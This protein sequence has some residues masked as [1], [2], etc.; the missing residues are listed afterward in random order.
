[1]GW[2]G[3]PESHVLHLLLTS[4]VLP[5]W[6]WL[7]SCGS[8]WGWALIGPVAVGSIALSLLGSHPWLP[9]FSPFST[10]RGSSLTICAETTPDPPHQLPVSP[11][12]LQAVSGF[13]VH[14]APSASSALPLE[15]PCLALTTA[16]WASPS[17][18][19]W[20]PSVWTLGWP[21]VLQGCGHVGTRPLQ[22]FRWGGV[23]GSCGPRGMARPSP[24][25]LLCRGSHPRGLQDQDRH[26][27]DTSEPGRP[28]VRQ[29]PDLA[30]VCGGEALCRL[31][32]HQQR[33]VSALPRPS[34]QRQGE[35][36]RP[37]VPAR[38]G[39]TAGCWKS[40]DPGLGRLRGRG[41]RRVV[42]FPLSP[43]EA[44]S[45]TSLRTWAMARGKTGAGSSQP[46]PRSTREA[47][48]TTLSLRPLSVG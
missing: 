47:G 27:R 26:L 8:C 32:Q 13:L 2:G 14:V 1:M 42:P 30:A 44:T 24:W 31:L 23:L 12:P 18:P 16:P 22:A 15:P 45:R 3:G 48:P 19:R 7:G 39:H 20:G 4:G 9:C 28:H 11:Y 33:Q 40:R 46:F 34:P 36:A 5:S 38:P 10:S 37:G 43:H 21:D 41:G 29:L 6:A 25:L 35:P 17:A